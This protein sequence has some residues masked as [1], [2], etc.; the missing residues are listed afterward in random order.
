MAKLSRKKLQEII[1][2]ADPSAKLVDTS[3]EAGARRTAAPDFDTPDLD[4][5]RAKFLGED[6]APTP[7]KAAKAA[8]AGKA[9]KAAKAPA[10]DEDVSIVSV[11]KKQKRDPWDRASRPKAV[12]VSDTEGRIIGRQG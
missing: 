4:Q 3:V 7:P 10:P 5:L 1:E 12:V 11:E 9:G 2:Q 6:A 8:K